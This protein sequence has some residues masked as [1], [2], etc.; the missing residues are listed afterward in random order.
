MLLFEEIVP[1]CRDVAHA[2]GVVIL[3]MDHL[4]NGI[5]VEWSVTRG[6]TYRYAVLLVERY[7]TAE[8]FRALEFAQ[9]VAAELGVPLRPHVLPST[10]AD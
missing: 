1:A 10:R 5:H 2:M 8:E 9:R 6:C 4:K 7:T 3:S